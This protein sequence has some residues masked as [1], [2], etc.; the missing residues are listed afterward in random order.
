MWEKKKMLVTSIFFFFFSFPTMF[1]KGFFLQCVKSRLC[2]V[3]EWQRDVCPHI[4]FGL[5]LFWLIDWLYGVLRP[6]QHHFSPACSTRTFISSVL[7]IG[8]EVSRSLSRINHCLKRCSNT[9][10]PDCESYI[11]SRRTSCCVMLGIRKS[12]IHVVKNAIGQNSVTSA[13]FIHSGAPNV[14]R[15]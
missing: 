7:G 11:E 8:L 1:A 5:S 4:T 10:L 13:N 3:R 15:M 6:L 2:V 14:W 12:V 9:R